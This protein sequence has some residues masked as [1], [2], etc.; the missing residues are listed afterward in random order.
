MPSLI[1]AVAFDRA[2]EPVLRLLSRDQAARI[3]DFHGDE[4][5]QRRIE[6]LAAKANEGELSEEERQRYPSDWEAQMS[7]GPITLH[8]EEHLT[9]SDVGVIMLR[10]LLRKQIRAVQKGEDPIGGSFSAD[11]TISAIGAG[12]FYS[13]DAAAAP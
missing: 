7:Q 6:K 2:T 10:R 12:N 9:T 3:V 1:D 8:S 4:A 13:N 5:L 11:A